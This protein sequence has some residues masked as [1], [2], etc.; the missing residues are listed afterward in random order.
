ML[1]IG[2]P[3]MAGAQLARDTCPVTANMSFDSCLVVPYV[4]VSSAS[5]E[6][7]GRLAGSQWNGRPEATSG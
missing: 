7:V 3:E 5:A 6:R 1:I 4:I 2:A